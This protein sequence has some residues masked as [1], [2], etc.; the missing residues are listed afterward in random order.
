M[1]QASESPTK[2]EVFVDDNFHYMEE[3]ERYK[4]GDLPT[5]RAPKLDVGPSSISSCLGITSTE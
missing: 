2:Y 1:E 4:A 5:T 3:D